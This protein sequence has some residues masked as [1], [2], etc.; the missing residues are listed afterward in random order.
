MMEQV[1]VH[2]PLLREIQAEVVLLRKVGRVGSYGNSN[3]LERTQYNLSTVPDLRRLM[4]EKILTRDIKTLYFGMAED[5]PM[6]DFQGNNNRTQT[7]TVCSIFLFELYL[8]QSTN[9]WSKLK[10]DKTAATLGMC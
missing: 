6:P 2:F 3:L 5:F 8:Q 7:F 10:I 9:S 1:F 4:E